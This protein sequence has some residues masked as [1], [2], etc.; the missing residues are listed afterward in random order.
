MLTPTLIESKLRT[1]IAR[2]LQIPEKT[3]HLNSTLMLDLEAESIDILDIR[4]IIEQTFG[5][6][7]HINEITNALTQAAAE[8]ALTMD[9][10][11]KLFTVQILYDHIL[12]RLNL[13]ND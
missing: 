1:I 12:F 11:P 13:K 2:S 7:F 4:F 8:H 6:K 9:D 3:V 10:I 5:F